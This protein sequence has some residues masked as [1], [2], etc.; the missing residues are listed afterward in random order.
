M[1]GSPPDCLSQRRS[2]VSLTLQELL[3]PRVNLTLQELSVP[4]VKRAQ[5][6]AN[7]Q[8]QPLH[9][10]HSMTVR[11][12]GPHYCNEAKQ[13]WRGSGQGALHGPGRV[14]GRTHQMYSHL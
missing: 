13:E 8:S 6:A 11:V 5:C 7:A 2:D 12:T 1:C 10:R 9:T 14:W 4:Q 3:V